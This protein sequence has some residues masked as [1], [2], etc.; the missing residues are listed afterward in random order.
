M[1]WRE[2]S[3]TDRRRGGTRSGRWLKSGCRSRWPSS[4]TPSTRE[5]GTIRLT[6]PL[7]SPRSARC[8]NSWE[9][10]LLLKYYLPG[11]L[12][13]ARPFIEI[14]YVAR[15]LDVVKAVESI[16]GRDTVS[17]I[18]RPSFATTRRM[19]SPSG[20]GCGSVPGG[21]VSRP[22]SATHVGPAAPSMSRDRAD[23]LCSLSR[24]RPSSWSG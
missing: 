13:P 23:S 19:G 22:R 16:F 2:A 12:L 10:P 6:V 20:E 4:S 1:P 7:A 18:P 21:C 3:A 9:F 24:I 15:H 11:R 17:G 5:Q 14:G 8:A